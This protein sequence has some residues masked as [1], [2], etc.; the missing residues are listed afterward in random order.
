VELLHRRRAVDV[1][2]GDQD[3]LLLAPRDAAGELGGGGGLA[4]ALEADHQEDG[5]RRHPG[6]EPG[7]AAE[8]PDQVIVDDLDHH[9]PGRDRPQHLLADRLLADPVDEGLDHR[10][11]HVGLEQGD[12]HLA[13]RGHHVG[14][15]QRAAPLQPIEDLSQPVG[16]PVEHVG[17]ASL[18]LVQAPPCPCATLADGRS[19]GAIPRN[20][21]AERCRGARA[22]TVGPASCAVKAPHLPPV[23]NFVVF[24]ARTH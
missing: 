19:P 1:E 2:R 20:R 13:Q 5:R 14:L 24:F 3:L 12:A 15:G 8:D 22:R 23:A 7:V 18:R 9:L 16:Q 21:R 4:R 11:R 10:Q 17:P 6:R